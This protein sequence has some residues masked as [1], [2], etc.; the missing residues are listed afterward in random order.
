MVGVYWNRRQRQNLASRIQSF[1]DQICRDLGVGIW[2]KRK[3]LGLDDGQEGAARNKGVGLW[4]SLKGWY[5]EFCTPY[6]ATDYNEV[7]EEF[8]ERNNLKE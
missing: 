8:L 5:T 1:L 7:T 4:A 3:R 2:R 6:F